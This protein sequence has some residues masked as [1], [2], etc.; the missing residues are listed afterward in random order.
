MFRGGLK[1]VRDRYGN[2]SY[3]LKGQHNYLSKD[4][5]E[6][7]LTNIALFTALDIRSSIFSRAKV[8]VKNEK[9]DIVENHPFVNLISD[10]NYSQSQS[11]FLY[12]HLWFKSLGNNITRVIK[13]KN[14]ANPK[15]LGNI[16]ALEHLIPTCIEYKDVNKQSKMQIANTDI[17]EIEKQKIEYTLS[18]YQKEIPVSDLLFFYD[19]TNGMRDG[20]YFKSPSRIDSLIP[21]LS[22]IQ[23]AQKSKN[24]NLIFS[25][26]FLT[27]NK[28]MD[29]H[30]REEM[31]PDEKKEIENNLF[32]KDII[33]SQSNLDVHSLA[34]DFTHL[35]YDEQMA[36]DFVRI[37]GAYGIT[38]EVF[39]WY[40]NGQDTYANKSQAVVQWIQN[41]IMFEGEDFANTYQ[42][43]FNLKESK[44]TIHLDYIHLPV[45]AILEDKKLETRERKTK[46]YE[47]LIKSQ[48]K[49]E[50]A[51]KISELDK[52][53][54]D[55]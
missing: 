43:F 6:I 54:S 19:V 12:K 7:S 21:E 37:L 10:P 24:V 25:R 13:T 11:D 29:E 2:I 50:D 34:N 52:V 44:E 40:M 33:A 1:V 4:Y 36:G 35:I 27:S 55:E 9:G 17:K 48:M 46:I 53:L 45:M 49:P 31:K 18:G 47:K 26:K 8:Y 51:M 32:H 5:L 30:M 15:D 42:N 38:K 16:Y 20:E 23:E 41:S 28:T 22:N 14:N 3:F 39:T